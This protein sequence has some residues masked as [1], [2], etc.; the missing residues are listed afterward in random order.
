MEETMAAEQPQQLLFLDSEK[1]YDS[2][3]L[4]SLCQVIEYYDI[5]NSISR[6]INRLYKNSFSKIKIGKHLS[7]G[8]YR[9]KGLRLAGSL[10]FT[11]F[12]IYIYR[13]L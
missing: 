1:A 13:M 2:V 12:K 6:A 3:P 8:F 5:S 11:L 10:S 7:L 9:T 4:K